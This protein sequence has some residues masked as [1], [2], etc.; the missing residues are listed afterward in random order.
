MENTKNKQNKIFVFIWHFQKKNYILKTSRGGSKLIT[1]V[2]SLS[3]GK[4]GG[5]TDGDEIESFFD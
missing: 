3:R 1:S 2:E 4:K 5:M